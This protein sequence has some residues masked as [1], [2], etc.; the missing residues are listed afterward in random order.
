MQHL[1]P[2][3]NDAAHRHDGDNATSCLNLLGLVVSGFS[4]CLLQQQ[5]HIPKQSTRAWGAYRD[6]HVP[7]HEQITTQPAPTIPIALL[8]DPAVSYLEAC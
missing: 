5:K 1:R 8:L 6:D 2:N 3:L 4:T 7:L